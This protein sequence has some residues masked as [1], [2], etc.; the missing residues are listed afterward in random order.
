MRAHANSILFTEDNDNNPYIETPKDTSK[1]KVLVYGG[2]GWIG[3][4]MISL[5]R[6]LDDVDVIVGE[7]RID[8][9]E[10]VEREIALHQP[11]KVLCAAGLTGRP[12]VDW[13][14]D[15]KCEV[16]RVNVL[17]TGAL[18]DCC[19]RNNATLTYFGTGCIYEYCDG[20]SYDGFTELCKPNFDGS[21]YSKTK[22][23]TESIL[24]EY[25]N[26]LVLRV[27]M[28]LSDDLHPRNFITKITKYEKVVNVPNSM[29]ILHE[30]LP[31]AVDM[32]MKNITG[33]YNFTNPGVISHN[34][35]LEL[36]KKYIDPTFTFENFS[37]E[38]QSK[39]LKAGRS[40]NK[41]DVS[42]LLSLYPNITP[43]YPATVKLFKRMSEKMNS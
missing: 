14:E 15:H 13:C 32:M 25:D 28:P 38:E 5:L 35:I 24:K 12:N 33:I 18:A 42:K 10:D 4:K 7:A 9:Y 3:G 20:M 23:I 6:K 39:I 11:H 2:S 17:A 40:N 21:F 31:I 22:I 1:C 30:L 19:H 29:T 37:I 8:N 27:R 26:V 43:I 41:L 36:Y 34:Q 16:L